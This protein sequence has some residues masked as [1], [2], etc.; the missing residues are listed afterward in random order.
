VFQFKVLSAFFMASLAA[1]AT[2]AHADQEPTAAGKSTSSESFANRA[3]ISNQF[4]WPERLDLS[5]LRQYG[6][7][8]D[9]M[10]QDYD[11]A[12]EFQ[13]LKLSEVKKDIAATLKASQDWWPADYGTYA[14]FFIRMAWHSAGTYRTLDGRGGGRFGNSWRG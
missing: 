2:A 11:Y 4:W 13:K 12:R 14:P 7:E 8:S 9:P 6:I 5:P 3:S 1:L 10:G